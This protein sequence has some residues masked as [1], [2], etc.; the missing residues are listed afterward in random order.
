MTTEIESILSKCR[1]KPATAKEFAPHIDA[2]FLR[3]GIATKHQKAG[4]LAQALH[5]SQDLTRLVE[6]LFYTTPEQVRRVWPKRF[7]TLADAARVLR[8]PEL[9]ANTVYSNWL[10]NGDFASGDGWKHR[11]RGIFQLTGRANYMAAGEALGRPY[12]DRPDLV[13][14]VPDAVLTAGWYWAVTGCNDCVTFDATTKKINRAMQGA[15][16]RKAI[17]TRLMEMMQ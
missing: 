3:F 9:L 16:E 7:A 6:N 10:G 8:N 5:E 12:K 17:Y 4:F 2:A 13:S 14:E 15:K 1:V 11:G